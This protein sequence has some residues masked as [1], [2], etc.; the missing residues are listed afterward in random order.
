[1]GAPQGNG[2][3]AVLLQKT[4]DAVRPGNWAAFASKNSHRALTSLDARPGAPASGGCSYLGRPW[5]VSYVCAAPPVEDTRARHKGTARR[6]VLLQKT[7]D[8]LRPGNR[9]AFASKDSRRALTS[10]DAHQAPPHLVRLLIFLAT[11]TE[12]HVDAQP[13]RGL[14]GQR[15]YQCE[16]LIA[17]NGVNW[18]LNQGPRRQRSLPSTKTATDRRVTKTKRSHPKP[19]HDNPRRGWPPWVVG[20]REGPDDSLSKYRQTGAP[21]EAPL[22]SHEDQTQRKRRSADNPRRPATPPAKSPEHATKRRATLRK[23]QNRD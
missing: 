1:M 19:N 15:M 12:L 8:A 11:T 6:A 22:Q 4:A 7:A 9:S 23:H 16:C 2:A 3:S 18:A 13:E 10:L 20:R 14:R 17:S 5:E 21:N